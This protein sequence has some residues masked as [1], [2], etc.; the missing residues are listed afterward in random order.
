MKR[1]PF[2]LLTLLLSISAAFGQSY[3]LPKVQMSISF[4]GENLTH[5]GIRVGLATPI[6]LQL[7]PKE[8]VDKSWVVGGY[9]TY[10]RHPRN[11]RA[12]MLTGAIGRQRIGNQGLQTMFNFELGYMASV[13]DAEAY[14]WDGNQIIEAG[15][16]SSH[17]TFG[18]NG[19]LGWNFDKQRDL[20]LSFMVQ[21]HL[22]IQAPFNSAFLPRL[23]LETRLIYHLK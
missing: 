15:K 17:F 16:T 1:T 7:N 5:P 12:L 3:T 21:P 22:F 19:G 6:G 13:L 18:L 11:H 8:E 4:F 14:E 2:F 20:P 23:A 9:V 10:Y